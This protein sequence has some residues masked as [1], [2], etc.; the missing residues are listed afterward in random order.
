M[1]L[2]R[3]RIRDDVDGAPLDGV[4]VATKRR[5]GLEWGVGGVIAARHT[6]SEDLDL[7]SVGLGL[8]SG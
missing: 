4:V 1:A 5:V 7:S 2:D 6:Q 8:V 3:Q